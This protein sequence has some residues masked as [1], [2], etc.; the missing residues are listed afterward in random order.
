MVSKSFRKK[1]KSR[2]TTRKRIQR[3]SVLISLEDTK[4]SKYYFERLIRDKKLI[5]QVIIA[6]HRGTDPNNVLHAITQ[7]VKENT[8]ITYEKSWIVIDKDDY[9]KAQINGVIQQARTSDIC[10]AI[11]NE[12]YELWILMHF[13]S[14]TAYVNRKELSSQLN[15]I[16]KQKFRR[17][18]SKSSQ[19]I[20]DLIIGWQP[21]A[22]ERATKLRRS[23]INDF[24]YLDPFSN[25]PLTTIYELINCLNSLYDKSR[26]CDCYPDNDIKIT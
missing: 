19:D 5:G 15:K 18:Y 14:V 7:H 1:G 6:K 2:N 3:K 21:I 17:E 9:S 8:N 26:A 12:S 4:S 16:F 25:N 20:Y 24:G 13:Q 10:V 22:I 23:Y 11:S